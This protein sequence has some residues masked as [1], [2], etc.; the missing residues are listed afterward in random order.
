MKRLAWMVLWAAC[1][2]SDG[3]GGAGG[4]GGGA[5]GAFSAAMPCESITALYCAREVECAKSKQECATSGQSLF[6]A[7]CKLQLGGGATSVELLE[8]CHAAW[9]ADTCEAF[10]SRPADGSCDEVYK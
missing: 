1:G 10:P 5:S 8:K 4:A 9:K 6:V 2:G 3:G 7:A